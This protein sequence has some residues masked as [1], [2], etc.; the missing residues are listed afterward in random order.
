MFVGNVNHDTPEVRE[1]EPVM[2]RFLRV[3]PERRSQDGMGLR[4][5]VLGCDPQGENT[6]MHYNTFITSTHYSYYVLTTHVYLL[7]TIQHYF[8]YV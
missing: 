3:Y 5:E 4:L 7:N 2:M 1:L 6:N 8:I